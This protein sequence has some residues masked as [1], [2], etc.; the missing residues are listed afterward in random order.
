M[1]PRLIFDIACFTGQPSMSGSLRYTIEVLKRLVESEKFDIVTICSLPEEEFALQNLQRYFHY[2]LPFQSKDVEH[3]VLPE[4]SINAE[5]SLLRKTEVILKKLFPDSRILKF[6]ADIIRAVKWKLSPPPFLTERKISP[7]YEKLITK[8]DI[9]F[10]TFHPLIPELNFNQTIQ[11]IIVIHDLIPIIFTDIY[12]GHHFFQKYPWDSI[13]PDTVVFTD[14]ESTKRDLLKFCPHVSQEQVTTILLAADQRFVPCLDRNKIETVLNKY[15]V[16]IN[17]PFILSVATL[18]I[19]KN[20]DHVMNSFAKY[21]LSPNGIKTGCRLV[22]TG[23]SGWQDRKFKKTF[24]HLPKNVKE[25][26]IFTGYAEDD[27]LPIL[28]SAAACFCYMSIYEGF[29]LP[30]LEAMQCGTPV[31]TSNTSSLPEVVGDAGIMLDPYD[32]EGLANAFENI[33]GNENSQKELIDKGIKQAK[34]FNWDRCVDRIIE[35]IIN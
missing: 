8:S 22:L 6:V 29:G 19:R 31:I 7:Y 12:K 15:S 25:K 2:Q 13:T 17:V 21:S 35:K 30:P 34:K 27:D 24:A 33:I 23:V 14:S 20:F 9:Y 26:I 5:K 16:P 28:Y 3:F 18:D 32:V 10:S 11:K 1:K 4:K